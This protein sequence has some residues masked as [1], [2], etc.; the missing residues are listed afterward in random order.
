MKA[1]YS[2]TFCEPAI[3]PY[4]YQVVLPLT[5]YLTGA[6]KALAVEPSAYLFI[7]NDMIFKLED[8]N[9]CYNV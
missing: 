2:K 3:P 5:D 4:T 6:V 7:S 8:N 9:Y 1:L